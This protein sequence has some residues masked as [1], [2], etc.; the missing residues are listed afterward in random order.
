MIESLIK[1]L[2]FQAIGEML[3]LVLAIPIPGPVIGMLFLFL[4]LVARGREDN[5]L[6]AF[7][8][9]FLRHLTLLFI[10]AAV[11]IMLHLE[12]VSQ[13]WLPILVALTVSTLVSIV[14]TA[15]VV[16]LFK[17]GA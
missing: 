3:V 16:Q 15:F 2:L 10:P 14:V 8:G 9:K 12:R 11:G 7:S 1:L 17:Q 13:E 5:N 6:A 4:Y